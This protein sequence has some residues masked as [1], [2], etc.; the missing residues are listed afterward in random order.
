MK[1]V[2]FAKGNRGLACLKDLSQKNWDV[3]LIVLQPRD[4]LKDEFL[5][6]VQQT[7]TEVYA[8]N[9]PNSDEALETLEKIHADI[10]VLAGYGLILKKK[11]FSIPKLNCINLHGGK[12]PNYR[13]SSPL[14]W[15]LINNEKKIGLSIIEVDEGIDTGNILTEEEITVSENTTISDL[16]EWANRQFPQLLHSVL[17]QI[18]DGSLNP[19]V[20][21][22]EDSG[23]YP[24]RFPDDGIIF[25]DKFTARQVHDR[26]RALSSPYPG[27]RTFFQN[28]EA[29]LHSSTLTE[30]PYFGE[31][32]RIYK[33]DNEKLLV[34]AKE[35]AIWINSATFVDDGSPLH[36]VV[37]NYDQL[38]TIKELAIFQM[39]NSK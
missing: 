25:W 23:Y 2:L 24:R 37:K 33:K 27:A 38:A 19:K 20:Q 4:P 6:I 29:V 36:R 39:R 9:N 11:C 15:A 18:S 14:N 8:P 26:I 7:G 21:K 28:R 34:G 12:L 22:D 32:G 10:F 1:I 5:K 31:S 16:H 35:Q 30:I 13:G 3:T 17:T